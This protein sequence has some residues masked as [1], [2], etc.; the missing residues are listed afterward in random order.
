MTDSQAVPPKQRLKALLAIPDSQR[1][2]EDWDEIIELEISLAPVNQKATGER[3]EQQA[4][5]SNARA[6]QRNAAARPRSGSG[7]K[8]GFGKKPQQQQGRPQTE[9]NV[10]GAGD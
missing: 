5:S 9:R 6:P 1:T 8:K 2:E 3:A 10:A 4:V 7:R